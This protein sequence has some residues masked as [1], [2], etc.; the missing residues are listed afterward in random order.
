M[1]NTSKLGR[2]LNAEMNWNANINESI[3]MN[4]IIIKQ[5][6]NYKSNILY[7]KNQ[8]LWQDLKITQITACLGSNAQ[9]MEVPEILTNKVQSLQARIQFKLWSSQP[10]IIMEQ[11]LGINRYSNQQVDDSK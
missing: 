11:G 3:E 8:L 1:L 5:S 9:C 2:R 6:N 10:G 7:Y 4:K